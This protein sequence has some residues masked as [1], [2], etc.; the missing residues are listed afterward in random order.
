[1]TVESRSLAYIHLVE[2]LPKYS[3]NTLHSDGTTKCGD[4]FAG[5]Q[6]STLD[7]S[8]TLCL[9]E[10]KAG[11]A[12]DFHDILEQALSDIETA[13]CAVIALQQSDANVSRF[14]Q[15]LASLKNAT[16]ATH[17]LHLASTAA[18]SGRY[19]PSN[20]VITLMLSLSMFTHFMQ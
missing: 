19:P 4:R 9:A 5:F 16:S 11:V 13:C 20:T 3:S 10:M 12:K 7:F 2:E 17:A 14:K 15:I 1:M 8:C 18:F 6:V